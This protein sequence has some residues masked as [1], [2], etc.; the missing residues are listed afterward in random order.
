MI[1]LYYWTTPNGHKVTMFLE[2]TGTPYRIIPVHIGK[3]EQFKPEFLA[4]APNNRI[5]AMVDHEPKGGGAP[6][7]L[8]ESGAML[9]YLAEKTGRFLP[10]E[11]TPAARGELLS[12]L[13]FVAT[14]VGPYSG[15]AV[16]FRHFA[17][18]PKEYAVTRYLFEARRHYGILDARLAGR[19]YVLGEDYTIVDMA[20]WG[21]ARM[22]PFIL[23]DDAWA[24][25][26]N[27]KR[28]LDEI[29]VRP[30]AERALALKDRH[31]FK[32]EM[33]EEARRH[34]FRHTA[35]AAA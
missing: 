25:M 10:R 22:V 29:G 30:A 27:L 3:G 32:T 12:W 11:Q 15:Q 14:G 28:L 5:P 18:E 19:R 16:H 23:G 7:S 8:F 33:D 20:V 6:I 17:P 35:P 31:A 26:P 2:E 24:A 21:W 9:L 34:M 1:D 4:I 13:M